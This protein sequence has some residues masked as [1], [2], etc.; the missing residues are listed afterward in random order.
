MAAALAALQHTPGTPASSAAYQ[1]SDTLISSPFSVVAGDGAVRAGQRQR[2]SNP[3]LVQAAYGGFSHAD[4]NGHERQSASGL[5]VASSSSFVAGNPLWRDGSGNIPALALDGH[6]ESSLASAP[7]KAAPPA[8]R[9]MPL[10]SVK[11]NAVLP[12]DSDLLPLRTVRVAGL[13]LGLETDQGSLA[14]LETFTTYCLAETAAVYLRERHHT[15]GAAKVEAA[16]HAVPE[17][18]SIPGVLDIC[19]SNC[20]ILERCAASGNTAIR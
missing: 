13:A 11:Q 15:G 19:D 6:L 16:L 5:L 9:K 3:Q 7:I 4:S 1:P 20:D 17:Q 18:Y 2:L 12:L 8:A 14:S 10:V